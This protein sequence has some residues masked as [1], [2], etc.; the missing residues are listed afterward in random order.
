LVVAWIHA[1]T[2]AV[3]A[4]PIAAALIAI[5]S[6]VG[7]IAITIIVLVRL[8]ADYFVD[9]KP[10][11]WFPSLPPIVR[12]LLN[13]L[14]TIVGVAMIA[15]GVVMSLP[16][17]PGQGVLTIVLGVMLAEVPGKRRVERWLIGRSSVRGAIDRVRARFGRPP[18]TP[19]RS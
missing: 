4:H 5:G 17:V 3:A 2:D 11:P 18:L 13:V 7:S 12:L 16:G 19:Q 9:P 10:P 6:F 14:R 8:P 15:L 1:L